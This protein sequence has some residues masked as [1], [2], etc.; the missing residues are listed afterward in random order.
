MIFALNG[1]TC[2][3]YVLCRIDSK[4]QVTNI[5]WKGELTFAVQN[6][7]MFVDIFVA[8]IDSVGSEYISAE[9][10]VVDVGD[11]GYYCRL[12]V[13]VAYCLLADDHDVL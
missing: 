6:F 11:G 3:P 12:S 8:S 13:V 10:V 7:H 2:K 1:V 5:W 4:Y 9:V